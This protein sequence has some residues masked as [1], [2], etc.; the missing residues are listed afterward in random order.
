MRLSSQEFILGA[1][2]F[3]PKAFRVDE[4]PLGNPT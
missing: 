1:S 2:H 3:I 4:L